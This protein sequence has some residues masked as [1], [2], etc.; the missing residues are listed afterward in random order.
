MPATKYEHVSKDRSPKQPLLL[1]LNFQLA[2][3]KANTSKFF[4]KK[5]RLSLL[6]DLGMAMLYQIW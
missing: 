1:D 3:K 5:K 2:F 6:E 4:A